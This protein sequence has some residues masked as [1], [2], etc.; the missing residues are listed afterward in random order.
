MAYKDLSAEEVQKF[1]DITNSV[2]DEQ[3]QSFLRSF[4]LQFQG[5]FEEVLDLASEFKHMV[6]EGQRNQFKD[7]ELVD[8]LRFLEKR[9]ETLT[10]TALKEAILIMDINNDK[11]VAFVE[12]C[13]WKFQKVPGVTVKLLLNPPKLSHADAET[14]AIIQKAIEEYTAA[15]KVREDRENKIAKLESLI[16]ENPNSVKGKQ[17]AAELAQLKAADLLEQN[18]REITAGANKRKADKLAQDPFLL[19]QKRLEE[20][21]KKKKQEDDRKAAEARDRL[22][23][24]A[25]LWENK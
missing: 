21:A 24:K 16:E 2:V 10:A 17:Y 19:E 11:R 6:P 9:K 1:A 4:V 14:A 7:L 18:R 3:A 23:A 13:L 20:E 15:I 8:A 25:S 22:K 12:Y 5:N